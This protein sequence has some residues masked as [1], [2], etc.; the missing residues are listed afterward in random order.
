M[1][2]SLSGESAFFLLCFCE[3]FLY[4]DML[5]IKHI[6]SRFVDIQWEPLQEPCFL[7]NTEQYLA[8]AVTSLLLLPQ[9]NKLR[10]WKHKNVKGRYWMQE[11]LVE[12]LLP[13][14]LYFMWSCNNLWSKLIFPGKTFLII[15]SQVHFD[16]FVT[17]CNIRFQLFKK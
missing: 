5:I 1:Q 12:H 8:N 11:I 3:E 9:S 14:F 6:L 2:K 7:Q 13:D 16:Q 17:N 10:M 15:S 4:Y